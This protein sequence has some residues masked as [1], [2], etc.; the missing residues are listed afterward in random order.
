MGEH[1]KEETT[2]ACGVQIQV[3]DNSKTV[4]IKRN[5]DSNRTAIMLSVSANVRRTHCYNDGLACVGRSRKCV[6]LR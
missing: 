6:V 1:N 4:R 5:A 2:I 3:T